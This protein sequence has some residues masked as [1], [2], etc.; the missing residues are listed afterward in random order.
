M[1]QQLNI[2]LHALQFYSRIPINKTLDYSED[3][4]VKSYRYFPLVGIIV[5][6]LSSSIGWAISFILPHSIAVAITL[7]SMVLLTGGLHEDGLADFFDGFGGGRSREQILEIM[8]DSTIGVYGVISLIL[9][10]LIKHLALYSLTP[11]TMIFVMISAGASSRFMVVLLV[12]YSIYS[13]NEI[14][15]GMHA[16]KCPDR[17]TLAI[18]FLV[19]TIPF[20]FIHWAMAI[21]I[22]PIYGVVFYMLKRYAESRIGGFTGDVLGA[23]Q[24]FCEVSFYMLYIAIMPIITR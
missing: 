2:L 8:K 9:L 21:L 3:N 24:Q 19:S 10:F 15:K 20:C 18:A 23:L 1:R 11:S 7:V 13:R 12:K 4:L 22:I 17:Q 5:C 16:R 14:S 6:A